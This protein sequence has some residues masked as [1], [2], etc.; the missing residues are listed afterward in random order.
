[1]P[2]LLYYNET[3]SDIYIG[4]W[5]YIADVNSVKFSILSTVNCKAKLDW[6]I[7]DSYDII[8]T[9][10]ENITANNFVIIAI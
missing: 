6:A 10:I 4:E 1:M 9:D 2:E 3:T 7:N 8:T 5:L